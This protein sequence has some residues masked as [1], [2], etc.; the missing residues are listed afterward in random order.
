MK[1]TQMGGMGP[2]AGAGVLLMAAGVYILASAIERLG[3]IDP[4]K[5]TIGLMGMA[6]LLTELIVFIKLTSGSQGIIQTAIGMVILGGALLIMTAALK[7][8]G[9]M[10]W[11]EIGRGLTVL[12]GSLLILVVAMR[13]MQTTIAGA[14]AMVI[15]SVGL[16]MLAGALKMF[17]SMSLEEIGKGLLAMAGSFIILGVAALVLSPL[18]G[19]IVALSGAIA[20]LG[21]GMLAVGAGLLLFSTGLAALTVVGAAGAAALI[22]IFSSVISLVPLL[23]SRLGMGIVNIIVLLGDSA[24]LIAEAVGS[25]LHAIL[26][27]VVDMIPAIVNGF[28]ILL[29]NILSVIIEAAPALV[30]AGMTLIT[31]LLIG[32]GNKIPEVVDAAFKLVINFINGMADAIRENTPVLMTAIANLTT[33]IIEGLVGGLFGGV[34]LVGEAIIDLGKSAL[35]G[36]KNFLGIRSPSKEFRA[37]GEYSSQGFADG[38]GS[39]TDAITASLLT[40]SEKALLVLAE[41]SPEFK[42]AG[43]DTAISISQG[44]KQGIASAITTMRLLINQALAEINASRNNFKMAGKNM[45]SGFVQGIEE[46]IWR[47]ARAA[48]EMAAAAMRAAR[49]MLDI[50]SPSKVFMEMGKHVDQGFAQGIT[51]HSGVAETAVEDMGDSVI[52]TLSDTF[53]KISSFIAAD[54]D[55]APTI[56]PV[57]DLTDVETG[58][59]QLRSL[60]G[61]AGLNVGVVARK[62]ALSL[63]VE[64]DP[65]SPQPEP[66]PESKPS[67]SFTQN[68]YSPKPLSRIDIYRQTRNQFS[69]AK[70][71][72]E[73]T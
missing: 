61:T 71:L 53:S 25:I 18:I 41:K 72:V 48:A 32:I 19:V 59:R 2:S 30:E 11:D 21:V 4:D 60:F 64:Q 5:L 66:L 44:L 57:I 14:A 35:D 43:Y 55:M 26:N 39:E 45:V 10:T 63:P 9:N 34:G 47:A 51:Q 7:S 23:F 52:K 50:Q 49:S 70:G 68:N 33:A 29:T 38:I 27:M 54:M 16:I 8:M 65:K 1:F 58:N 36:L 17:G 12:A 20:L 56:K 67:Y 15:M 22:L 24:P 73:S 69:A 6:A 46:D 3:A 62:A 37:L 42:K 31:S 13:F 28:Y 40:M